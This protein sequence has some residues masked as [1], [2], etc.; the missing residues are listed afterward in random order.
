MPTAEKFTVLG[1]FDGFHRCYSSD[2]YYDKIDVSEYSKWTTFSG[3]SNDNPEATEELIEESHRLALRYFWNTYSFNVTGTGSPA[4]D[5][6]GFGLRS[7]TG[8]GDEKKILYKVRGEEEF[9]TGLEWEII[10]ESKPMDRICTDAV[11]YI[12]DPYEYT[13]EMVEGGGETYNYVQNQYKDIDADG[14]TTNCS[15]LVCRM[16]NGSTDDEENFVG[17]GAPRFDISSEFSFWAYTTFNN[18]FQAESYGY[19][20]GPS[21]YLSC[22]SLVR[23]TLCGAV[24]TIQDDDDEFSYF[25]NKVQISGLWFIANVECYTR[26]RDSV[27]E[28]TTYYDGEEYDYTITQETVTSDRSS[29]GATATAVN[30]IRYTSQ[31][32]APDWN[33]YDVTPTSNTTYEITGLDFW[34]Y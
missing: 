10:E 33:N 15:P 3:V 24:P 7:F 13:Q 4:T 34:S 22:K 18:T 6:D 11:R 27:Q 23:I 25:Q 17:W 26:F 31:S 1:N 14:E 12:D 21:T 2:F 20:E 29:T 32:D 16:Y 30:A 19:V 8:V 28:G 5:P 9:N